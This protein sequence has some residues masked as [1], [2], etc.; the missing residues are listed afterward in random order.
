MLKRAISSGLNRVRT[1]I[2][3]G[4]CLLI[5]T[6]MVFAVGLP[7]ALGG[8]PEALIPLVLGGMAFQT[9]RKDIRRISE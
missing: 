8:R 5:G 9:A 3:I 7:L 2:Q 4:A 1:L 6:V